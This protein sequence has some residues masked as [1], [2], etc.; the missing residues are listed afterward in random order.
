MEKVKTEVEQHLGG[1]LDV[2]PGDA[3]LEM[4]H[5]AAFNVAYLRQRVGELDT[6][7]TAI[8]DPSD[9]YGPTF[10]ATGRA[11]GEGKKHVLVQMYDEERERLAKFS[12]LAIDAAIAERRLELAEIEALRLAQ[13]IIAT[14]DD[15]QLGLTREQRELARRIAGQQMRFLSTPIEATSTPVGP[16]GNQL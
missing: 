11:T 8:G 3:L 6:Q 10:H 2:D 1:S 13:V 16:G 5:E 4:C 9:I 14:V 7:K 15:P 12:K